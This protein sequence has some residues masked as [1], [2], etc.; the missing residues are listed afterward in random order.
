MWSFLQVT[1]KFSHVHHVYH[2][3]HVLLSLRPRG[4]HKSHDLSTSPPSSPLVSPPGVRWVGRG[5]LSQSAVP[6]SVKKVSL[7]FENVSLELAIYLVLPALHIYYYNT[8]IFIPNCNYLIYYLT[9]I[10]IVKLLDSKE[11]K[12]Y[13]KV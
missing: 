5:D 3:W 1:H 2:C 6:A 8:A 7:Q 12:N 4:G 9:Y 10:Q 11:T 13:Q